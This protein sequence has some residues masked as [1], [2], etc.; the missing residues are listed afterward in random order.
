MNKR[1]SLDFKFRCYGN[2]DE[3]NW[4]LFKNKRLLLC[5]NEKSVSPIFLQYLTLP[6]V[7]IKLYCF[8][9]LFEHDFCLNSGPFFSITDNNFDFGRHSNEI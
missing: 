3:N 5:H 9:L 8:K 7:T 2:S 4:P 1:I 6:A